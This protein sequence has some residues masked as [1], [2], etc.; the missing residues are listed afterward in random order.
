MTWKFG[1]FEWVFPIC[2]EPTIVE[3][4]FFVAGGASDRGFFVCRVNSKQRLL[5][6]PFTAVESRKS[7]TFRDLIAEIETWIKKDFLV[8]VYLNTIGH[9][10][11]IKA[12]TFFVV[13]GFWEP[14]FAEMIC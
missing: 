8:K 4:E 11:D 1:K 13:G 3:F 7:S 5:S 14:W 9:Y 2:K 10:I 6:G 12:V